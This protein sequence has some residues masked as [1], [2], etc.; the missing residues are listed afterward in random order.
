GLGRHEA[1]P[2]GRSAIPKARDRDEPSGW[3]SELNCE[4]GI[5]C[6]RRGGT[7]T[8]LPASPELDRLGAGVGGEGEQAEEAA[9]ELDGTRRKPGSHGERSQRADG[10][11]P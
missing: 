11:R 1:N 7:E 2:P 8:V 10:R 3:R 4:F 6:R 5:G 9:E